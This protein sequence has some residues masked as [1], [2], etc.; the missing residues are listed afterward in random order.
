MS[1][2]PVL[3]AGFVAPPFG[4]FLDIGCGAGPLSFLLLARDPEATRRRRRDSAAAGGAGGARARRQRLGRAPGDRRG[5]RA[6]AGRTA[7]RG[8]A[9]IWS[10]PTRR[11]GRS[12]SSP[13][14]PNPERA[15]ALNEIALPARGVGRGRR[16]RRAA[17][18]SRRRHPP[19][20]AR[21]GAA[22]RASEGTPPARPHPVR[23]SPRGRAAPRACWW[24]RGATSARPL[25]SS[26]LSR[27]H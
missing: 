19:G 22:T 13:P 9:S 26:S 21:R 27:R 25:S 3:L 23:L 11:T 15:L 18:R 6:R 12:T 5:R 16:P 1:L 20:G 14:S 4:R 2:D 7:G 17:G 8:R 24:K 10:S